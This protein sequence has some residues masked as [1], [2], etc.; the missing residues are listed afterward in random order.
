MTTCDTTDLQRERD[1]AFMRLAL[2]CAEKAHAAGEVPVGAVLVADG[3]VIAEGWNHP[4]TGLDPSAHAEM[5]ALRA[6]A[7]VLGNYRLLDTTLYVTLEPCPMCIGAMIHARVARLV[8]G[9]YDHKTGAVESQ[10]R[11]FEHPSH[12]H[13]VMVAGGV[14][15]ELCGQRLSAFFQERRAAKRA[16]KHQTSAL[17]PVS[18]DETRGAQD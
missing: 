4:I 2:E 5:V 12:N 7:K 15:A 8:F 10:M 1:E 11:L 6:G 3:Q 9:A 13:R 14:L 18:K 16:E 17:A